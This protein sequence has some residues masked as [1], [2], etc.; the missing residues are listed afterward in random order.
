MWHWGPSDAPVGH[1]DQTGVVG[2][3]S[4]LL[5]RNKDARDE[6]GDGAHG[7]R[8]GDEH[9]V[10]TVMNG[11]AGAAPTPPTPQGDT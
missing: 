2:F 7:V 4:S 5:N 9:P 11:R 6:E 8:R 1:H 10:G 3:G